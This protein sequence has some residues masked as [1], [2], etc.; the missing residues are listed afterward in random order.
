MNTSASSRKILPDSSSSRPS[1]SSPRTPEQPWTVFSQLIENEAQLNPISLASSQSHN[2]SCVSDAGTAHETCASGLESSTSSISGACPQI[3]PTSSSCKY[4]V[5]E[6]S[7]RGDLNVNSA[8]EQ[9]QPDLKTRLSALAL[10]P[11]HRNVLK[12][13]IAYFSASLF[14]FCPYLSNLISDL[15]SYGPGKAAPTPT[16]HMVATM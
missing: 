7:Y 12:C 10:S 8:F 11:L 6:D 13:S 4:R 16:G 1:G 5:S 14:T 3:Y 15:V 9:P 2:A